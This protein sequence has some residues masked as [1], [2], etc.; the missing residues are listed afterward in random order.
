[1]AL[2]QKQKVVVLTTTAILVVLIHHPLAGSDIT[3]EAAT[4]DRNR[5]LALSDTVTFWKNPATHQ[6]GGRPTISLG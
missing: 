2:Q 3:T 6:P 5:Q 4:T 1:L